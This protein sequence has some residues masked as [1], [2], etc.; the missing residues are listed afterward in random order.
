MVG[1]KTLTVRQPLALFR[2]ITVKN[3]RF[4]KKIARTAILTV[5][6]YIYKITA[7]CPGRKNEVMLHRFFYINNSSMNQLYDSNYDFIQ[8]RDIDGCSL[9][10]SL[11][12]ML[13]REGS[14]TKLNLLPP[15]PCVVHSRSF[16]T[17]LVAHS[18]P[19]RYIKEWHNLLLKHVCIYVYTCVCIYICV[20]V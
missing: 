8:I 15:V 10:F 7:K 4:G 11:G 2:G 14:P 6:A 19:P 17:A 16:I 3:D 20:C 13:T 1:K 18:S 12:G 9:N 5:K